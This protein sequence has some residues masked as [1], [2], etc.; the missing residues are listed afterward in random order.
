MAATGVVRAA[1]KIQFPFFF[2]AFLASQPRHFYICAISAR[3][4]PAASSK[5][6]PT[7][8]I[9]QRHCQHR[10][11]LQR[12]LFNPDVWDRCFQ[13]LPTSIDRARVD[14][15][16]ASKATC[17]LDN[18]IFPVRAV[19]V[20]VPGQKKNGNFLKHNRSTLSINLDE[21]TTTEHNECA[22]INGTSSCPTHKTRTPKPTTEHHACAQNQRNEIMP[23]PKT[24]TPKP[25]TEHHA[26][27]KT[28]DVKIQVGFHPL[29]INTPQNFHSL[30]HLWQ[31][32]DEKCH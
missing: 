22:Q 5:G 23:R 1:R 2:P 21:W 20:Q 27:A 14:L 31:C 19:Q 17:S 25:T 8:W 4:F 11:Y 30:H 12:V 7:F 24:R 26:R 13:Q 28:K 3:S 10:S 15:H 16:I 6:G 29:G 18:F 9:S 32:C